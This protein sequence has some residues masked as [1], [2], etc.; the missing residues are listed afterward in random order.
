MPEVNLTQSEADALIAMEKHRLNEEKV[1]FPSLGGAITLPL[2]SQDRREQFLLD[3][4]RGRIELKKVKYQNRG[5]QV[6][7]LA[8]LDVNG[9]AHRNPDENDLPC[10]HL[11][12]YREGYADKWA[13]SVPSD[14]FTNLEDL[15][16]TLLDFQRYCNITQPP[17]IEREIFT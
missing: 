9:S 17:R 5:R 16:Q 13:F 7:V 8:R 1:R 14:R 12:L 11:H 6:V 10:P 4:S 2:Q 15:W 3:V